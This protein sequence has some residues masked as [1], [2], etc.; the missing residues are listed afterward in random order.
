MDTSSLPNAAV[1]YHMGHVSGSL[2]KDGHVLFGNDEETRRDSQERIQCNRCDAAMNTEA[3]QR[4]CPKAQYIHIDVHRSEIQM[5][6]NTF[7]NTKSGSK[8]RKKVNQL[9]GRQ[10][11]DMGRNAKKEMD[12][13]VARRLAYFNENLVRHKPF[14]VPTFVWRILQNVVLKSDTIM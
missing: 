6:V 1:F 9:Y 3:G 4:M 10:L 13:E 2:Y 11:E 7:G 8:I 12:Q 5:L 14:W